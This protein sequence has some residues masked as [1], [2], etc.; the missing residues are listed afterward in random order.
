MY[1]CAPH[2]AWICG[3]LVS[4]LSAATHA[5]T[6]V[7]VPTL[8]T[9]IDGDSENRFPFAPLSTKTAPRY[10]Q[11]YGA[12]DLALISGS[13]IVEI[14]FRLDAFHRLGNV[15]PFTYPSVRV[16]IS[17]RA[18]LVDNLLLNFESNHG[19]NRTVVF[20]GPLDMPL[21]PCCEGLSNAFRL[22]IPFDTPFEYIADD[23][24]ID[25]SMDPPTAPEF[26]LDGA[27]RL[28][29]PGVDSVSRV[30]ETSEFGVVFDSAG[31]VTRFTAIEP[32]VCTLGITGS[33][34]G[35]VDVALT[36]M[37][38][39]GQVAVLYSPNAGSIRIPDGFAC[40]GTLLSLAP[41]VLVGQVLTADASGN[42]NLIR[43]VP[44]GACGYFLQG[45]DLTTCCT[46][47][48]EQLR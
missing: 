25:I 42:A 23:V 37:T 29:L 45:I 36:N 10:Q 8:D 22:V 21:L 43:T 27:W 33:C 34:P 35:T 39:F 46:T 44:F 47:E 13:E 32:A 7:V 38:P 30:F 16:E 9:V 15:P 41:P 11:A 6:T 28:G 18:S 2:V 24:L 26:Y 20:D 17:T 3:V 4:L 12:A 5:Q 31:L 40:S 1:H 19:A 48:I 14:A